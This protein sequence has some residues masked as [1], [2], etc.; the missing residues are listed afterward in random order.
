MFVGVLAM[1][2]SGYPVAFALGGTA[3]LFAL[4]G[5]AAGAFDPVLLFALPD[6]AF[7]TMSN[8]TLL[9]VPFFIFMGTVLEKSKLAERLLETIGMLFGRFRGG[10]AIGVIRQRPL[11]IRVVPLAIVAVAFPVHTI[12]ETDEIHLAHAAVGA[13]GFGGEFRCATDGSA[14]SRRSHPARRVPLLRVVVVNAELQAVNK[15]LRPVPRMLIAYAQGEGV[16]GP[17]LELREWDGRN[18]ESEVL[19]VPLRRG[20]ARRL[21][22]R[23]P[24]L[25][26]QRNGQPVRAV[27]AQEFLDHHFG[28]RG[29]FEI[30]RV[31]QFD[32]TAA[33]VEL[34]ADAQRAAR[35]ALGLGP[36]IFAKDIAGLRL[37]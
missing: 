14:G 34:P 33:V 4:A 23:N 2:F 13:G 9:A 19:I 6:R 1:I 29:V 35:V 32:E 22:K 7:G 3:L 18:G 30:E 25:A 36:G 16:T 24:G 27:V 21:G 31:R 26:I 5:S 8:S 37:G 20:N 28:A 17:S 10:L 11:K 12:V 15:I